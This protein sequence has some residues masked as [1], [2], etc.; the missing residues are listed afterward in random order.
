MDA[1][2]VMKAARGVELAATGHAIAKFENAVGA[3]CASCT[4]PYGAG[5]IT[6]KSDEKYVG[7]TITV[8][9]VDSRYDLIATTTLTVADEAAGL[10]FAAQTAEVN[11]N[12]KITVNINNT[13]GEK[14]IGGIAKAIVGTWRNINFDFNIKQDGKSVLFFL[15]PCQNLKGKRLRKGD[16]SQKA[17]GL[18]V[19]C[20][21]L[22]M[23]LFIVIGV[24]QRAVSVKAGFKR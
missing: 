8:T 19:K 3:F 20:L 4:N 1:N 21:R 17:L 11:V 15:R 18:R 14:Y 22:G 9:A 13:D 10:A 5:H 23:T 24:R 6:V 12:N 2:G 7:S 16:S